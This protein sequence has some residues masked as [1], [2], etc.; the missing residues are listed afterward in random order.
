MVGMGDTLAVNKSD[1]HYLSLVVKD[2]V[3]GDESF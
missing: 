3:S 1:K 2:N